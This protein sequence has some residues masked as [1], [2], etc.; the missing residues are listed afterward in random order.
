MPAKLDKHANRV[1]VN[2]HSLS[3]VGLFYLILNCF[4]W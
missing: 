3:S 1:F 2:V 4:Q